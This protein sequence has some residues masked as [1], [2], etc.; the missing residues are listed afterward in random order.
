MVYLVGEELGGPSKPYW[1]HQVIKC[2]LGKRMN[3]TGK[4]IL[5]LQELLRCCFERV[6]NFYAPMQVHT[7]QVELELENVSLRAE[8]GVLRRSTSQSKKKEPPRNK[9]GAF[10]LF[11]CRHLC[12]INIGL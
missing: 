5:R 4:G 2:D 8:R 7:F 9:C 3:L 12:I 10:I 1:G 11:F 6:G